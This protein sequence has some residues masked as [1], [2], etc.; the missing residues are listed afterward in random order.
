MATEQIIEIVI[1][2]NGQLTIEPKQGF[3]DGSCL[4]ETEKLEKALGGEVVNRVKK[5]EAHI[6]PQAQQK[7]TTKG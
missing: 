6:Q 4:K 7:L 2:K 1:D 3:K 5:P